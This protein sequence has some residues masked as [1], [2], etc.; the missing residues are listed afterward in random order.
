[1]ALGMPLLIRVVPSI[2]STATSTSGP[3]FQSPTRSPLNSIGAL[4]FSPSPMTTTPR[5]GSELISR[6]IA[7][8]AA[9]SPPSL[10]PRPTQRPAAI[11]AASVTRTRSRARLRSSSCGCLMV[12]SSHPGCRKS[13]QIA[14]VTAR[15]TPD[16]DPQPGACRAS[17]K[18]RCVETAAPTPPDTPPVR[19]SR[20]PKDMVLSLLELLVPMV[21]IVGAYR[22]LQEGDRPVSVDPAS[23]VSQARAQAGFPVLAPVGLDAGWRPASAVFQEE[24]QGATLRIG[25]TTPSGGTVQLVESSMPTDPLFARELGEQRQPTGT[26]RVADVD[27]Q[28]YD[29]RPGETALV[30]IEP[31]R[32]TVVVGHAS[33]EELRRLAE[34]LR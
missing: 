29:A 28:R 23:A 3:P 21:L 32:T 13:L 27:W 12:A 16:R 2:G 5:M 31:G 30:R 14:P 19:S 9:P 24:E 25:Y 33:G 17:A 15:S 4:S 34:S 8:T 11:A 6:R 18:M 20:T 22:I 1:M 10:S 26:V 7:S